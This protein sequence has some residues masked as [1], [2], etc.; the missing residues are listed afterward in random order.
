M[1]RHGLDLDRDIVLV[2]EGVCWPAFF[3]SVLWALYHRL[4]LVALGLFGLEAVIGG[5]AAVLGLDPLSQAVV[6]LGLAFIVGFVAND[7]RRWTL[8]RNG[9]E[10]FGVVAADNLDS[11]ERR[12]FDLHPVLAAELRS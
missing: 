8:G 4:W 1:R 5:L 9:F 2:K 7:L 3:F 12:F 11:A 10:E 6:S